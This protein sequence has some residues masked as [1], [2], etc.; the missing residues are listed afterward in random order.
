MLRLVI[1]S[2]TEIFYDFVNPCVSVL[3]HK[4]D[5][6]FMFEFIEALAAKV[7]K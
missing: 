4:F 7:F 2:Y 6:I 5:L 1:G 3:L